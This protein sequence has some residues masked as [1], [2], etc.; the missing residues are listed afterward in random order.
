MKTQNVLM[1]ICI[2]TKYLIYFSYI[3][4]SKK[5]LYFIGV[6][7]DFKTTEN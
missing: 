3:Y 7:V 1:Y 6:Q 2:I 5:I 4:V